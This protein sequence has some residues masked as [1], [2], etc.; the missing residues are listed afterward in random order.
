MNFQQPNAFWLLFL[1]LVPIIIHLFQFRRY[2]KLLFSNVTFLKEVADSKRQKRNL[3]H[4]LILLTRLL[5]IAALV[6]CLAEPN[7]PNSNKKNSPNLIILDNTPSM[8]SLAEGQDVSVLEEMLHHINQLSE[9]YPSNK[10]QLLDGLGKPFEVYSNLEVNASQ[11]F[12]NLKDA[13]KEYAGGTILLGSDYQKQLI[14]NNSE[15]L[16]DSAYQ[17]V[18]WP[19]YRTLPETMVWDSVWISSAE[20]TNNALLNIQLLKKGD[21]K[22]STINA[23]IDNNSVGANNVDFEVAKKRTTNISLPSFTKMHNRLMLQTDDMT[24]FDNFFYAVY[25]KDSLLKVLYLHEQQANPLVYNVFSDESQFDLSIKNAINFS[26]QS[27]ANYNIAL[28]EI[29]ND[30]NTVKADRL[31][32]FAQNGGTLILLP[33]KDF[34]QIESLKQ[35]GFKTAKSI[36]VPTELPLQTPDYD[37][38]FYKGVFQ[39][40]E[41]RL[42]MAAVSLSISVSRGVPLLGTI[43]GQS[44]LIKPPSNESIFLFTG[45]IEEG[46]N[47][48]IK[49]PIFLPV[50]YRMA[51]EKQEQ[52]N[53]SYFYLNNE[54]V[55]LNY[56]D[57]PAN[58]LVKLVNNNQA[59]IPDQRKTAQGLQLV[60]PKNELSPGFWQVIDSKSNLSYGDVAFNYPK[61]EST[62]DYYTVQELKALF[63]NQPNMQVLDNMDFENLSAYMEETKSDIPLWKYFLILALLSLFAEV[64]IIRF[65]K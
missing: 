21:G 14:Q 8:L 47:P 29:G 34:N 57:I 46:K 31:K 41:E 24:F 22:I 1:L 27:L 36:N 5:L 50:M 51:F 6:F 58:A 45:N 48:F 9:K 10:L 55:D 17:F 2:K 18:L 26:Y 30:F 25:E 38:P 44:F 62:S 37:N 42:D 56:L 33:S 28:V 11:S 23:M 53:V 65:I 52:G 7:W 20:N 59:F 64:F 12:I 49:S 63:K 15:I 19:A 54:V 13:L 3:K 61:V 32:M 60:I 35:L 16:N 39:E 40:R 43:D 4:L